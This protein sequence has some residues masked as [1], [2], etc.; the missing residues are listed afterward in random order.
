MKNMIFIKRAKTRHVHYMHYQSVAHQRHAKQRIRLMIA[1]CVIACISIGV[2]SIGVRKI[3]NT[4][5]QAASSMSSAQAPLAGQFGI[6]TGGA[7]AYQDETAV[8]KY[9]QR[10]KLLGVTWV[11]FDIDWSDVQRNGK[12]TYD[13]SR[14][15]RLVNAAKKQGLHPLAILTYTPAWARQ[16]GCASHKCS[17]KDPAVFAGFAAA[18]AQRYAGQGVHDWEIWNEPNRQTPAM[19]PANFVSLVGA[20]AGQIKRFDSRAIVISGGLGRSGQGSVVDPLAYL[21][22]SY[23]AGLSRVSD[24]IALHPY[25]FPFVPDKDNALATTLVDARAIMKQYGDADKNVW[26]TEYGAPTGGTGVAAT[27]GK[28]DKEAAY[29]YVNEQVQSQSLQQAV[30]TYAAQ[31]HMGPFFWFTLQDTTDNSTDPEHFFGLLY[32]SG[33]KKPAYDTLYAVIHGTAR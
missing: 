8:A 17:P 32:S 9:M 11:R 3:A 15:D 10:L 2:L 5:K 12:N 7:L 6:A 29:T 13:W 30:A 23:Q 14:Y 31:E 21:K 22:D 1:G 26:I 16:A 27:S 18:A 4:S 28:T 20:A 25:S 19:A 33:A 24:G